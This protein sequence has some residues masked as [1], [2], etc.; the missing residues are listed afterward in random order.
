MKVKK[1]ITTILISA[2]VIVA[3]YFYSFVDMVGERVDMVAELSFTH[4]ETIPINIIFS[5]NNVSGVRISSLDYTK[6]EGIIRFSLVDEDGREIAVKETAVEDTL[7]LNFDRIKDSKGVKVA[8]KIECDEG[9]KFVFS[10]DAEV[11]LIYRGF[12][13]E[14]MIVSILCVAYLFGLAKALNLIFRK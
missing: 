4:N 8:L 12:R 3:A 9:E 10:K 11:E 13:L 6:S 14:T 7:E 2:I 5:K 1:I